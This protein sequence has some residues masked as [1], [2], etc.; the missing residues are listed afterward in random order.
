MNIYKQCSSFVTTAAL[1]R[2]MPLFVVCWYALEVDFLND[3]TTI[4]FKDL[5]QDYIKIFFIKK[6][7]SCLYPCC[8]GIL[9]H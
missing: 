9:T 2:M 4:R 1:V 5:L 3:A 6:R 7:L 8:E